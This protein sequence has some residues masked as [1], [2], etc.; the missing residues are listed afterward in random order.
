M[1]QVNYA[2]AKIT[3]DS[4]GG[5]IAFLVNADSTMVSRIQELLEFGHE[6]YNVHDDAEYH[7]RLMNAGFKSVRTAAIDLYIREHSNLQL[8]TDP[9]DENKVLYKHDA[10]STNDRHTALPTDKSWAEYSGVGQSMP[11]DIDKAL[12]SFIARVRKAFNGD[13]KVAL[14]DGT[15]QHTA[16]VLS[17]LDAIAA[18]LK[19]APVPVAANTAVDPSLIAAVVAA[20]KAAPVEAAASPAS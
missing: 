6:H 5:V 14:K 15:Q 10:K 13:G 4:F 2:T 12:P 18:G 17:Q 1:S 3:A 20:M 9:R 19:A 8:V 16:S 11:L 7:T